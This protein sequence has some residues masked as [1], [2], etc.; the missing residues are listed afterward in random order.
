MLRLRKIEEGALSV[1]LATILVVASLSCSP[2][3]RA[4]GP[5]QYQC[6]DL[7]NE[8]TRTLARTFS[9]DSGPED[10]EKYIA[11][12][13]RFETYCKDL[14]TV[15]EQAA[16][17]RTMGLTLMNDLKRTDEAIPLF[18]RCVAMK[19][20]D[21]GCWVAMGIAHINLGA[22]EIARGDFNKAISIGGYDEVSTSAVQAAKEWLKKM[23]PEKPEQEI[24]TGTGFFVSSDGYILTAAHVANG[25]KTLATSDGLLRVIDVE[26]DIDLALLKFDAAI[27][28]AVNSQGR[29]I[30]EAKPLAFATI[31]N[32]NPRLGE[33]VVAFGFPLQGILSPKGNVSTGTLSALEGLGNDR[34]YQI[35]APVQPGNSGGPLL[36]SAGNLIGV[37]VAKLDALKI[38][39]ATGDIPEN[40]NFAVSLPTVRDFLGRY[41]RAKEERS[42]AILPVPG[43][44]ERARSYTILITCRK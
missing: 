27:S 28:T 14:M 3:V 10:A 23:P 32:G 30:F 38:A 6:L 5:H 36:D 31:R 9:V 7:E 24:S 19:P 42:T 21:N 35:S 12:E 39:S 16:S 26:P 15:E 41:I 2:G 29:V 25:C 1:K 8:A 20:D 17:A 44:A 4:Q 40:V 33:S 22:F 43:I 34:V 18:K 37:V 13:R 11:A